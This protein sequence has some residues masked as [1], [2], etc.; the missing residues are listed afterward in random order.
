[1]KTKVVLT[2]IGITLL[3]TSLFFGCGSAVANSSSP[4]YTTYPMIHPYLPISFFWGYGGLNL[5]TI[6]SISIRLIHL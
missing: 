3:A 5:L 1:M 2:L 4:N 6:L